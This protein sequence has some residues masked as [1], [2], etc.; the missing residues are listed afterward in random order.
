MYEKEDKERVYIVYFKSVIRGIILSIILLLITSLVFFFSNLDQ[1]YIKTIVWIIT[2]V[3]ICYASIY[4]SFKIGSR[5][6]LHGALVGGIYTII[7]TII[8]LL[9]ERG[10]FNLKSYGIIFLMSIVVGALAGMIGIVV[11]NKD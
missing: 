10:M 9:T 8:A 3:S 5:G 7:I 4:A 6:F 1:S 11:K 2:I